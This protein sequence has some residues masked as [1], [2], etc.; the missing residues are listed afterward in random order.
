[1]R[2]FLKDSV[3]QPID[4]ERLKNLS[5]DNH[6]KITLEIGCGVGLHPLQYALNFPNHLMIAFEHTREKFEKFQRRLNNHSQL[7]NLVAIHGNAISWITHGVLTSSIDK[8]FLLYP[9]PNPKARDLNK[10]W[11]AMPFMSEILRVLKDDGELI[12]ATNEKSYALEAIE[13]MTSEW[14]C[15]LVEQREIGLNQTPEWK[16]RTH[17]EKK[18]IE[19]GETCYNL[20]FRKNLLTTFQ[21]R[22]N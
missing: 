21:S 12:I 1:M 16:A 11:H 7:S 6:Q 20:R 5:L 4:I 2:V 8:L 17:F 10:R 9:N 13:W 19:R 14:K 18:Y 15:L 3:P 22:V